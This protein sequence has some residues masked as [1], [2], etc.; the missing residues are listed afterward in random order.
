MIETLDGLVPSAAAS[1]LIGTMAKGVALLSAALMLVWFCGTRHAL[2][3]S[4]LLRAA[5]VGLLLLPVG[6]IVL[7]PIHLP[8]FSTDSGFLH[9]VKEDPDLLAGPTPAGVETSGVPTAAD[10][11]RVLVVVYGLG[12]LVMLVRLVRSALLAS[13][14][15]GSVS[16]ITAAH[17]L[18]RWHAWKWRLGVRRDLPLAQSTRVNTPTQLGIVD[19]VVV[20]PTNL[21]A[22]AHTETLDMVLVHEL[23]HVR[24]HD[25]LFRLLSM[26]AR[27]IYWPIPLVWMLSGQLVKA[28][29]QVCDDWA[30][31]A[32]GDPDGYAG[33]LLYIASQAHGGPS[34]ALG[35]EMARVPQV[36]DRAERVVKTGREVLVRVNSVVG[37]VAV[38][39]LA[40]YISTVAALKPAARMVTPQIEPAWHLIQGELA[41]L[42]VEEE[43]P[44]RPLAEAV[45][46]LPV[47]IPPV[48]VREGKPV[49]YHSAITSSVLSVAEMAELEIS[50]PARSRHASTGSVAGVGYARPVKISGN[51]A[52][53]DWREKLGVR[54][55]AGEPGVDMLGRPLAQVYDG[56]Q[57][58]FHC[59]YY[60]REDFTRDVSQPQEHQ[61]GH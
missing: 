28:Q 54:S 40:G 36:I 42:P 2:W 22:G 18:R 59:E 35:L 13:A 9:P 24:G 23:A 34:L 17:V 4:I 8:W 50:M 5:I 27:A 3:K 32:T 52:T 37:L 11:A 46:S 58:P 16:R 44:V 25:C 47:A 10:A 53:G 21:L 49:R 51:G 20:L 26:L 30:V 39:V 61:A 31:K 1:L 15:R 56:A 41:A 57:R 6:A 19:P 48:S 60:N 29:E 33:S 14:V 43:L 45:L 38:F 55:L 12:L 7:T